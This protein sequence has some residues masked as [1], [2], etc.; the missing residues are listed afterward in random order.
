M[1]EFSRKTWTLLKHPPLETGRYI[2]GHRGTS[3]IIHYLHPNE[4]WH[5]TTKVGWQEAPEDF[6]ATHYMSLPEITRE[7]MAKAKPPE[8]N[9]DERIRA[10]R[11][12]I[13]QA[14]DKGDHK[15][16]HQ[17]NREERALW[18]RISP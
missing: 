8:Q 13:Q 10:K 3:K 14:L 2:V 7:M 6:G 5:S 9:L 18:E 4:L 11:A 17:L 12:E 16:A 1:T 15:R